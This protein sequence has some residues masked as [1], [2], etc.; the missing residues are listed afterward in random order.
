MTTDNSATL[1]LVSTSP[2]VTTALADSLRVMQGNDSLLLIENAV[3][4][5]NGEQTWQRQLLLASHQH[6]IYVLAEDAALRGI[7]VL[8][9]FALIDYESM[10]RLT[11]E[12]ARTASWF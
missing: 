8:P 6:Q 2:F 9:P 11:C 7:H 1:H 12:H 3:W 4:A 5:V 10:V